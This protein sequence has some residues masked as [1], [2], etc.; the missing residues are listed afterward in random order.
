[1]SDYKLNVDLNV[2]NHLG[3]NLYSNVSAV[4]SEVIANAW[5]ADASRV[6]IS[7]EKTM[8]KNERIVIK[9]NGCGMDDNDLRNKFL[10]VGYQ[11]RDK[12]TDITPKMNRPVMG[13]KGI[14]KLSTLS[15]AER[16]QIITKKENSEIL[17][18]ELNVEKIKKAIKKNETYHPPVI[19]VPDGIN[20]ENAGTVLILSDFKKRILSSLVGH[21]RQRIARR[22]SI[23][24]EK[25]QVFIDGDEVTF[26]DRNYFKKLEHSLVYGNYDT[27]DFD[28]NEIPVTKKEGITKEGYFVSGWI[29][30]VDKPHQ[31]KD[32]SGDNLNKISII[33]RGKVAQEDIL[34]SFRKSGLYTKYIVGEL[35]A[36]FLDSTNEKDIA[37]SSRENFV[38]SDERFSCLKNFVERE[39]RFLDTQWREIKGEKGEKKAQE[40]P[41]IKEWY[42]E[43][44]EENKKAAK[45][46]FGE[47]NA[48]AVDEEHRKILLK[49]G[50]LAF[51]HMR[52]KKLLDDLNLFN[53][54]NLE[55]ILKLFS[56][57]DDIE[58]SLYY[59]I[60]KGRL[61]VIEKLIEYVSDNVDEK[62]L[63]E[64]IGKHLWLLDPSWDKATEIPAE[65]EKT[66]AKF[67]G[68]S[69]KGKGRP[70]IRYRKTSSKHVIVELKKS[71]VKANPWELGQ[72]VKKY[73]Y[74]LEECLRDRGD[75]EAVEA[76]CLV[77]ELPD[78]WKNEKHRQEAESGLAIQNIKIISYHELIKNTKAS[79]QQYL[80]E[81][82]EAGK[83][84][85]LL[86]NIEKFESKS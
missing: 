14:G 9:D 23:F 48:I 2:L 85:R 54:E 22:F 82:K 52:H 30:L 80:D 24:S 13:R 73:M 78:E 56:D 15:I 86:T 62:D 50:V 25:F 68:K 53:E 77:G 16:V 36:D 33:V 5:D 37:T 49:H 43:L 12:E 76:I 31:L 51:T 66:I 40:N 3:L 6:D 38:E 4:L 71:S 41:A 57:L 60:T 70:D 35:T 75:N 55:I 21:L 83:L 72:Q 20:F 81:N 26:G 42:E 67:Y 32:E 45:K 65:L 11:R 18:I 7:M 47:I 84:Q 17:A 69:A 28:R 34:A 79:Y 10:T 27:N 19:S 59:Q 63:Q 61:D 64:H 44:N 29:G 8:E 46:L 1:M 39:L 58:A 74:E